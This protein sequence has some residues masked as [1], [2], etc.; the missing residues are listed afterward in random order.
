MVDVEVLI[1]N[2]IAWAKEGLGR[3]YG[4]NSSIC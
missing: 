3:C 1:D 4:K 2:T